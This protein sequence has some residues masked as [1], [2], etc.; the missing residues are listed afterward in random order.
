MKSLQVAIIWMIIFSM[1]AVSL[2]CKMIHLVRMIAAF[3]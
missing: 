3:M 1:G 2:A